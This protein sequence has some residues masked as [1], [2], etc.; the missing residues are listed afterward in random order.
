MKKIFGSSWFF[1][2]L[3]LTISMCTTEQLYAQSELIGTIYSGEDNSPLAGVNVVLLNADS[4]YLKATSTDGNGDYRFTNIDEGAF[5]ITASFVG[6]KRYQKEIYTIGSRFEYDITMIPDLLVIN[7]LEVMANFMQDSSSVQPSVLSISSL[8]IEGLAGGQGN[9]FNLLKAVPG[10]TSAGDFSSQLVVRGGEPNQNLFFI[11]EIEIYSP[12]QASGV[13]SIFNKSLIRNIDFFS[14]A[15]PA[16][17]GDRLS[18][19]VVVHTTTGRPTK[20]LEGSIDVNASIASATFKGATSG[21]EG[22]WIISGRRT[23]YDTFASTFSNAVTTKNEVAFPDFYDVGGLLELRPKKGHR[24]NFSGLYS[25]EVVDWVFREDQFGELANNRSDILGDQ[26]GVNRALGVSYS[27][28]TTAALRYKAYT[29]WYKNSGFNDLDGQF[30]PGL[31]KKVGGGPGDDPP[32][33]PN[34]EILINYD[35]DTHFQKYSIGNRLNINSG[36]HAIELGGG[37][38]W[39]TNQIDADLGLNEYGTTIFESFE[40]SS[41]LLEAVADTINS[42]QDS[43]RYHTYV[44][45]KIEALNERLFFQPGLR[46]TYYGINE[47]QFLLPRFGFSWIPA[48]GLTVRGGYGQYVQSPGFEKL[49]DPDDIFSVSKF[50]D[51]KQLKAEKST[52]YVLGVSK[53]FFENWLIE[54]EGYYKTFDDLI[55][56]RY[57][58]V[59]RLVEDYQPGD[60][61]SITPLD[62]DNYQLFLEEVNEITDDPVNNGEGTSFGVEVMLQK[63]AQSSTD[64]YG[65]LSYAFAHSER[66]EEI[67]GNRITYPFDYDRP[68]TF[69]FI[70]N[71]NI[72]RNWR[73]GIAWRMASGLPYTEPINLKPMTYLYQTRGYFI[74]DSNGLIRMNPDFGGPENINQS[75]TPSYSRLDVRVGYNNTT[76]TFDYSVYLEIINFLNQKNVQSYNY[77][78]YIDDPNH[79]DVAPWLR[80][81]SGVIMRKE[82]VFMYP[83]LPSIGF[84]IDF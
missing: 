73:F 38:D 34:D 18:S 42:T 83:F 8:Q 68:H 47:E 74:V 62:P 37:V 26:E 72:N 30:K 48:K 36:R 78:L 60:H 21:I 15:F 19:V 11:D 66:S 13:G 4:T 14:G 22:D 69:N 81:P 17:Y 59:N 40:S 44:Q 12:Y 7:E 54:V 33:D 41:K 16:K 31:S 70:L 84:S 80:A 20:P 45:D 5:I 61:S 76:P 75:R 28:Q 43:Y 27:I 50:N 51:L 55:T 25:H 29:N 64:W 56:G 6:F 1:G 57:G 46:Y 49:I 3:F 67:L 39:M 35:Q 24:I 77:V 52:Q 53:Q 9:V 32:V 58:P 23:Y 2:V 10:V 82:P 65:W 79:P 71:Q 63:Y